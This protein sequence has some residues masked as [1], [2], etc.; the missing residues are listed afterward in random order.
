MAPAAK[1][2]EEPRKEKESRTSAADPM[3]RALTSGRHPVV[4]E[5]GI[6]GTILSNTIVDEGSGVNVLP[7][8]T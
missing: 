3:L 6:L 7:E 2:P 1:L 4:V 8:D 5:M